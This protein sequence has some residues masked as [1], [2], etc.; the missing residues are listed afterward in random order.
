MKT[1]DTLYKRTKTGDIQYWQIKVVSSPLYT[2]IHKESG[3]LGTKNPT[4]HQEKLTEGKNKGRSNATSHEQQA[5]LQAESDWKKKL[6]AGYKTLIDLKITPIG[7]TAGKFGKINAP[8]ETVLDIVLP[9]FNTDASGNIKPMLAKTVDWKKVTYPCFI[10]P[11]LDGVRCLM[12]FTSQTSEGPS[13]FN[14]VMLSR[15]G[16]EYTTLNHIKLTV[17]HARM[18]GRIGESFILDGEIYSD[19]LTFQEITQAVKKQCSNSL[20]LHFRAYDIVNDDSQIQRLK[21]VQELV[22]QIDS[23]YVHTV[24]TLTAIHE[25]QIK[26]QHDMWVQEGYEGAMIRLYDGHYGQG[27]RSS[28][29]LKVKEFDETEFTF[30]RFEKGQRDEDLIAVCL[31]A[32]AV[33]FKAKM[34]G[35]KA[36]KKKLESAETSLRH[37]QITVKHFG[38]TDD[39]LPRF[40]IGKSFRDYE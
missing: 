9:Q 22:F 19:E 5:L 21:R 29:L 20:K 26:E 30:F 3:K 18:D 4:I 34:I 8:L 16:K 40:P 25:K 39:G 7:T 11:K 12:V 15:N 31:S 23:L 28:Y 33:E 35:N 37:L 13:P 17:G 32:R 2:L 27:Q 24:P 6:D 14:T 38:Y 1:F 10:Q 36:S